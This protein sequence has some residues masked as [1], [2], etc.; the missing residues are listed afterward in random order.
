MIIQDYEDL[1][2][3]YEKFLKSDKCKTL[4]DAKNKFK[5]LQYAYFETE[6]K[7]FLIKELQKELED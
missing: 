7:K 5:E 6:V 2:Y 4:D 1:F 3:V